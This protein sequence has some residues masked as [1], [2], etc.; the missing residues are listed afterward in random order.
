[1]RLVMKRAVLR[2]CLRWLSPADVRRVGFL[3]NDRYMGKGIMAPY[4]LLKH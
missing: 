2:I 1:M 4:L 3:T